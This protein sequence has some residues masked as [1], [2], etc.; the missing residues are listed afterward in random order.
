MPSGK[1][2]TSKKH[3]VHCLVH[4]LCDSSE[5][6]HHPERVTQ[7]VVFGNQGF[8]KLLQIS[9]SEKLQCRGIIQ[10]GRNEEAKMITGGFLV[11]NAMRL[12]ITQ[13]EKGWKVQVWAHSQG[14]R[15]AYLW[16]P[17]PGC[18]HA[19]TQPQ[20]RHQQVRNTKSPL[21]RPAWSSCSI[22]KGEEKSRTARRVLS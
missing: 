7:A 17:S 20:Y 13:P 6:L 4:S 12:Q 1:L 14:V 11:A 5:E 8:L 10:G 22:S 16:G 19:G 9:C 3:V 21:Q 15:T 2:F 18:Q